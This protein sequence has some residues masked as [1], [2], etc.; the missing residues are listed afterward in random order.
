MN[1]NRVESGIPGLDRLLKGGIPERNVVLLSGGPGTGKSI[2]GQ[3][4]LYHG[5]KNGEPG[6]L[7]ALE[8]HPVQIRV[9]MNQLGWDV[10]PYESE[11]LFALVDAFTAG[12]GEAAKRERYVVPTPDDPP[13]LIDTMRLAI[14][15]LKAKRVV[16]DSVNT[17]YFTRPASARSVLLQLKKVLAGLG[18]TSIFIS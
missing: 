1:L 9:N 8:E 12:I 4:F 10:K 17:I 6:V 11:G 18:T 14:K 7:V 5:L 2:F 13:A 16:I 15:E 3:Q